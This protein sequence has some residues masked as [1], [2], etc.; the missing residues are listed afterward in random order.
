[1]V[2]PARILEVK[3][4][5]GSLPAEVDTDLQ[6]FY[7][8]LD[9]LTFRQIGDMEFAA[10]QGD[11]EAN[12]RR[13][14]KGRAIFISNVVADRY[15]L[16][17]GDELVLLTRRGEQSFYIAAEVTDFGGQGQIIYGTYDDLHRWFNEQGVDR[18]TLNLATGIFHRG[19][20][21]GNR[22]ALQR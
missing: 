21:A 2:T 13:L 4:A 9:P 11:P 18:F 10:N 5:S 17:Q 16:H 7:E 12:W 1:M 15:N 8:A 22:K 3:A 19:S 6:F 14:S 20:L